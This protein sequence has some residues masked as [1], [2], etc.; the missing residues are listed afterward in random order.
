[1]GNPFSKYQAESLAE[2]KAVSSCHDKLVTAFSNDPISISGVLLANG[3]ISEETN[4]KMLLHSAT[5]REK[6]T[7]LVN[8]VREKIKINPK[9][10]FMFVSILSEEA[11][12]TDIV[13]ILNSAFRGM[14]NKI[15]K[16]NYDSVTCI[17]MIV[18]K[19]L[20]HYCL[21]L[22]SQLNLLRLTM[23][24]QVNLYIT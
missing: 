10:F 9:I 13:D 17:I 24:Y 5:P 6:S 20:N 3:I 11:W 14:P 18:V 16:S 12:T 15:Q 2:Y 19:T 23:C 21:L 4:A 1:M 22:C 7:I 8:S